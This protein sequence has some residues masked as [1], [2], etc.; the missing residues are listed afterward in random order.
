MYNLLN[1]LEKWIMTCCNKCDDW[2]H[3]YN[4]HS[5]NTKCLMCGTF[6]IHIKEKPII[7]SLWPNEYYFNNIKNILWINFFM[8]IQ[9]ISVYWIIFRNIQK[10]KSTNRLWWMKKWYWFSSL[11]LETQMNIKNNIPIPWN[12]ANNIITNY[13]IDK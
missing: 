7:E 1:N 6:W 3:I 12:V 10:N 4:M 5:V 8:V 11:D 2:G 13:Y 9:S